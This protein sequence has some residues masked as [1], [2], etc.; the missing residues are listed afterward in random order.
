MM[1]E[2]RCATT[3]VVRPTIIRLRAS[4]TIRSDSVSCGVTEVWRGVERCGEVWRGVER[5]GQREGDLFTPQITHHLPYNSSSAPLARPPLFL[6]PHTPYQGAGGLVQKHDAGV[7]QDGP[8]NGN[9]LLLAPGERQAPLAHMG[10]MVWI[11]LVCTTEWNIY[12]IRFNRLR[13]T[14]SKTRSDHCFR[15][16]WIHSL[17]PQW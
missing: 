5:G 14:M 6:T 11:I 7:F 3:T 4:W 2:R 9:P 15:A 1:V 10:P 13:G 12:T 17:E 8:G 16:Q